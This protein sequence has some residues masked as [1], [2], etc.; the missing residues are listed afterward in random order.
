MRPILLAR[1]MVINALSR[2]PMR[3]PHI[4]LVTCALVFITCHHCDPP[5]TATTDGSRIATVTTGT[6]TN[7]TTIAAA[8]NV[9]TARLHNI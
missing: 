5:I 1:L 9:S 2:F 8:A 4:S 7:T 6:T 3:L